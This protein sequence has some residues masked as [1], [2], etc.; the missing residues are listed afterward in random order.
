MPD[1]I[2]PMV[3]KAMRRFKLELARR[4]MR[5]RERAMPNGHPSELLDI[6]RDECANLRKELYKTIHEIGEIKENAGL[7]VHALDCALALT[8][9]LFIYL[10]QGTI[11]P[12]AVSACKHSLDLAMTTVRGS[13]VI[14]PPEP[15]PAPPMPTTV[16]QVP[17]ADLDKVITTEVDDDNMNERLRRA[18]VAA[19]ANI[20]TLNEQA[21]E[22]VRALNA[23]IQLVD[24]VVGE[25]AA[26]GVQPTPVLI[27]L[28]N[29]FTREMNTV[30][31]VPGV[32]K[33]T[34]KKL[35]S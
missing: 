23:A 24:G 33:H 18:L 11:L 26:K 15:A 28:H 3:E 14:H 7:V 12:E 10:P 20:A 1:E 32:Q 30:F 8:E 21:H 17:L 4:K 16:P 34:R 27:A 9:Q 22:M 29:Q 31:K 2:S 5:E 35:I 13:V 6:Y 25:M 19:A